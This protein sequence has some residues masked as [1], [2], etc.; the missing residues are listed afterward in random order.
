M[1]QATTKELAATIAGKQSAEVAVQH[2]RDAAAK[3]L[4]D[5]K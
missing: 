2:M 4:Q 1:A 5:V 3:N